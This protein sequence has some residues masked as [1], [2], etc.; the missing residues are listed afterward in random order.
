MPHRAANLLITVKMVV[1][2]W[3][4]LLVVAMRHDA[5]GSPS[6]RSLVA[7]MDSRNL[8][9][10]ALCLAAFITQAQPGLTVGCDTAITRMVFTVALKEAVADTEEP[11]RIT[12]IR[13]AHWNNDTLPLTKPCSPP[14]DWPVQWLT[15]GTRITFDTGFSEPPRV[16]LGYPQFSSP[17]KCR[18]GFSLAPNASG[19]YSGWY[20]LRKRGRHWRV[21][22]RRISS[23]ACG[24]W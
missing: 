18:V 7:R 2:A 20:V 21:R 23:I 13:R 19:S 10:G 17:T 12:L 8:L 3:G 6:R 4:S 1:P 9:S 24:S 16:F 11:G 5:D 15:E 22:E 14:D